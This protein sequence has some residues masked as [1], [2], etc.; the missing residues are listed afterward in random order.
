MGRPQDRA[1]PVDLRESRVPMMVEGL[2]RRNVCF[3]GGR[4]ESVGSLREVHWGGQFIRAGPGRQHSISAA[5]GRNAITTRRRNI[6]SRP[7]TSTMDPVVAPRP[8]K[9]PAHC[10]PIDLTLMRDQA[11]ASL[12]LPRA[13]AKERMRRYTRIPK[14]E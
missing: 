2:R 12:L 9:A 11:G 10:V 7:S 6:S 3:E 8:E 5:R 4:R 13:L 1:L 14:L